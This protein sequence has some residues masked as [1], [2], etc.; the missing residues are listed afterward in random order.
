MVP[1]EVALVEEEAQEEIT[2]LAKAMDQV[3]ETETE[4]AKDTTDPLT[5]NNP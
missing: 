2:N 4:E 3:L 5:T 1:E